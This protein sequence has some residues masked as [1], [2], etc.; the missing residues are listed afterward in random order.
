[1]EKNKAMNNL[2]EYLGQEL[3]CVKDNYVWKGWSCKKTVHFKNELIQEWNNS[4]SIQ[5][6]N[7]WPKE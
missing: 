1:M 3:A 5:K 7:P 4:D 2:T 6:K